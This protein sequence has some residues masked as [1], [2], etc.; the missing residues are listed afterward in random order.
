MSP[1]SVDSAAAGQTHVDY[2][3]P[4]ID[5]SIMETWQQAATCLRRS[6]LAA[7]KQSLDAQI[8]RHAVEVE[9]LGLLVRATGRE[10]GLLSPDRREPLAGRIVAADQGRRGPP[11]KRA[12]GRLWRLG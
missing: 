4:V 11:G 10:D 1:R 5:V 2:A 6:T 8:V 12:P 7:A 3:E 9:P